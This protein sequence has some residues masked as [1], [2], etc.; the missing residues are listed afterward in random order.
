MS[1]EK[2]NLAEMLAALP[3]RIASEAKAR[4]VAQAVEVIFGIQ[5]VAFFGGDYW[6]IVTVKSD[7]L[8]SAQGRE[9]L[10]LLFQMLEQL[11]VT[12]AG[13]YQVE[14]LDADEEQD[15]LESIAYRFDHVVS[16]DRRL[17]EVSA[18]L[19]RIAM[20]IGPV[21]MRPAAN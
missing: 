15:A 3:W 6:Q 13:D 10:D 7:R 17:D 16:L 12:P 18:K 4:Q 8:E 21:D 14:P 9:R 5:A 2:T 1:A 11:D 19:D 20:M